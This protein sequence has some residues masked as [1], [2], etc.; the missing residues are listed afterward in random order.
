MKKLIIGITSLAAVLL[1]GSAVF[2]I[3]AANT[4]DK[5]VAT[6]IVQPELK[7]PTTDELLVLVNAERA[8]VGVA[9]L[10]NDENV[11]RSAQLKASDF[12]ARDYYNHIVLGSDKVITPEMDKLLAV[13]CKAS[14][15]NINADTYTAKEAVDKWMASAPH[16]NAILNPEYTLTGFGISQDK[17]GDYYTV[18]HFCVAR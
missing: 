17:D 13:S 10:A 3:A 7:P 15:E 6:Q 1:I 2:V 12:S 16:H 8:K 4:P 5:P 18:Q 9:P 11:S 14:T